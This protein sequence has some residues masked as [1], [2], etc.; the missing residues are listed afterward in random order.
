MKKAILLTLLVVV[1]ASAAITI[2]FPSGTPTKVGVPVDVSIVSDQGP[3]DDIDLRVRSGSD[4]KSWVDTL[5]IDLP[6]TGK[7]EI[8]HDGTGLM[9][10]ANKLGDEGLSESFNVTL[11]DPVNWQILAPGETNDGG[12]AENP[13]GKTG[14][15][16][17]TAGVPETYD[18]NV[19]DKWY[20]IVVDTP[21]D[22]VIHSDDPFEHVDDD[23]VE[24][25]RV[26]GF[27]GFTNRTVTVSGGAYENDESTVRVN[28]NDPVALLII[29]PDEEH[30][31]GDD[32]TSNYPGKSGEIRD[33]T[34]G[35]AYIVDIYAVDTCWNVVPSY[36]ATDVNVYDLVD[37]N[38]TGDTADPIVAGVAEDVEVSFKR[39][40]ANEYIHAEVPPDGLK[41]KYD[42]RLTV[43]GGPK[44]LNMTLIHESEPVKVHAT[45]EVEALDGDDQPVI[46]LPVSIELIEGNAAVFHI[47]DTLLYTEAP[48][49]KASTEIWADTSGD[50]KI[51]ISGGELTVDTT[52]SVYELGKLVIY[53][54]PFKY[55][56]PVGVT[57][58]NFKYEVGEGGAD[59]VVLLIVDPFGNIAYKATYDSGTPLEPGFQI[60]TWDGCN[61]KGVRVA[62]GLYQAVLRVKMGLS[63]ETY[64]EKFMVIW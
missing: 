30:V 44:N 34:V 1:A 51:R 2:T 12:N 27:N 10:Y 53:P 47:K 20:N 40:N 49:G 43:T 58:I 14:N 32:S 4:N 25:R 18:V 21:T 13:S 35:T 63:T 19:C 29:T 16:V 62:S 54:N 33:A 48:D 59:E 23:V 36:G 7:I 46:N 50:Y 9:L 15:S 28:V 45:L 52:F 31:P 37:E 55:N 61:S 60:I 5:T 6:F 41:T 26:F 8:T 64:P 42:T 38:L 57:S 11:G 39:S 56:T 24:L 17:V 3:K 22:F